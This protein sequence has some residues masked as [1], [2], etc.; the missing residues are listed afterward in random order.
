MQRESGK[1]FQSLEV[2]L[3]KSP[4]PS[5]TQNHIK[6]LIQGSENLVWRK[7]GTEIVN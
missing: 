6:A 7:G 2:N 1:L 3:W 4:S 5:V